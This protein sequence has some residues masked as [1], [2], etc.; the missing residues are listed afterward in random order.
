[1]RR[2]RLGEIASYEVLLCILV[3]MIH[4]LSEC[5]D[6]YP[7]GTLM[8]G[9]AFCFSRSM[10]FVVPAFIISAGIKFANKFKTSKLG[11]FSFMKGRI[12]KIY[13]PYVLMV[14]IYYVYF[15]F[16]LKWFPFNTAELFEYIALGTVAAPFYFIIIMMQL[17][18]LAPL[19]LA[20]YQNLTWPAG[21]FSAVALALICGFAFREVPHNDRIFTIYLMYWVIGFYIGGDFDTN[22]S[23]LRKYWAII[24]PL[25]I[26]FTVF[27]VMMAYNEFGGHSYGY[28]TEV[29]KML[30][31]TFASL[32]LLIIMPDSNSAFVKMVAPLTFYIYLIHCLFIFEI[33][34]IMDR[35][36]INDVTIRFV[37]RFFVVYIVSFLAAYLYRGL[38]TAKFARR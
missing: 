18:I 9:I 29:M 3:V 6:K 13:L 26:I 2:K 11:Y 32:S 5:I 10:T 19:W 37:I 17:Y 27:Y 20:C 31:S 12:L 4:I 24:I 16:R 7:K 21:I 30:F 14:V 1:M 8:S 35:C 28:A 23:R 33:N 22:I 25:G 34:S 15:C 36:G 38:K